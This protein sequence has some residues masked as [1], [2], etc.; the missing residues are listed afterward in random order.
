MTGPPGARM[1]G[2]ASQRAAG[3]A[4]PRAAR[5]DSPVDLVRRIPKGT[6]P[7]PYLRWLPPG[8]AGRRAAVGGTRL[9]GGLGCVNA[10]GRTL[11]L[12]GRRPAPWRG[13]R[14]SVGCVLPVGRGVR[15]L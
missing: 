13:M 14:G 6:L 4:C 10:P 1:R 9:V 5:P 7:V 11:R 2:T 12:T 3:R 15:D 8:F